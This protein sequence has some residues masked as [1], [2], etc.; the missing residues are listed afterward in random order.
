MSSFIICVNFNI[1]NENEGDDQGISVINI[2]VDNILCISY[3]PN[4]D[5]TSFSFTLSDTWLIEYGT[6]ELKV[7]VI[8]NDYDVVNDA[9]TTTII[10][11][12]ETSPLNMMSYILWE[13][14]ELKS[15]IDDNVSSP[16][17]FILNSQLNRAEL[18]I[19][20]ALETFI[21]GNEPKSVILNK[22]AKANLDMSDFFTYIFNNFGVISE[23]SACHLISEL[24]KIRDHITI[25]MGAIVG[26]ECALETANIIMDIDQLA[27]EIFKNQDFMVALS[28][29]IHLWK[30][31]NHLDNA[32]VTMSLDYTT[33]TLILDCLSKVNLKL[34]DVITYLWDNIGCLSENDS[35]YIS[36]QI[37]YI[38]DNITHTMGR[39]VGTELSMNIAQKETE[40][41]QFGDLIFNNY[42][43]TIALSINLQLWM[44]AGFLDL[45]LISISENC[46]NSIELN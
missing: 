31:S 28:I 36:K 21:L 24:H 1:L 5:E 10:D 38:R 27:D 39:L 9:L 26:T 44:I 20:S 42:N 30:A 6:H 32:L 7:E 13:I 2:Y 33:I 40:I 12:F 34:A 23:S 4:P 43:L 41:E 19:E 29:D 37:H 8:D 15:F 35:D 25:T 14:D 45:T 22:L 17:D 3:Y 18:R 11:Y 46:T 16:Y